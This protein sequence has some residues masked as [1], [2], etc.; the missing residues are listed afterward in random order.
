MCRAE[1]VVHTRLRKSELI[2][3]ARV[4]KY[5]RVTVHVVRGTKLPI[6]S[7]GRA[8]GDAV[9]IACPSPAHSVAGGDGDGVGRKSEFVFY[10]SHCHIEDVA[11][12]LSFSS[13][14]WASKL[15]ENT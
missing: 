9:K 13:W 10:R 12:D 14:S 3:K 11:A 8:T 15:I 7:A 4:V 6:G 2:Y 1:V 5:C